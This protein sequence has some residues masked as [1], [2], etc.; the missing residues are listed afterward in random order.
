MTL[1][2]FRLCSLALLLLLFGWAGPA[3][4]MPVE[5]IVERANL[6]SYYAG[7]DGRSEVQ[8]TITDAQGR[9]RQRQFVILR[10]NLE[11]GGRQ[12]Y[13]VY[14]ERPADVRR[15]VFMVHKY[16]D[17][18]DDR[19]LFL[20]DLDLVRRI[21]AADKRSSFAGSHF[22]YEDVSGRAP[23][24]DRH[25]LAEETAEHY[26]LDVTPLDPATV[27]FSRY[28]V[29]IDKE[30]FLPIKAEYHDRSDNIYRVVEALEIEEIDGFPTVVKSRVR[31]LEGGG[32][33]VMAFAN[34]RYDIGLDESL[35][36]ER[37]LRRPPREVRR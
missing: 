15:M 37:F 34:V 33:T 1:R 19:W 5:E 9:E 17:R 36:T 12:L 4:A 25:E 21:A 6:A 31:D 16:L 13:Y 30:S 23:T 14:F 29:W 8:M 7:S 35:F 32:E 11:E 10:L 26:I 3:L 2:I 27:E 24:E 28:R 20:P 18:D 22:L